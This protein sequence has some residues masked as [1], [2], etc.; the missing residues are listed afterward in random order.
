MAAGL[1][2]GQISSAGKGSFTKDV[3]SHG[4]GGGGGL[5]KRT[6][7]DFPILAIC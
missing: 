6:D 7:H 2:L 4:M 3:L 1:G 5:E